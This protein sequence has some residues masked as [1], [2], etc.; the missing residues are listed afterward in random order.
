MLPGLIANPGAMSGTSPPSVDFIASGGSSPS[1]TTWTFSLTLPSYGRT[2]LLLLG[3]SMFT[4]ANGA[5]ITACSWN[6]ISGTALGTSGIGISAN[7]HR[8]SLYS[9]LVPAGSQGTTA[10]ISVTGSGSAARA[11]FGAWVV[12]D[13]TSTTPISAPTDNNSSGIVLSLGYGTLNAGDVVVGAVHDY[14]TSNHGWTWSS[15]TEDYDANVTT[16]TVHYSGSHQVAASGGTLTV[17]ATVD[18]ATNFT[19]AVGVGAAFR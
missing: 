8:M 6:G 15:G 19:Y 12:K 11:M 16:T 13:Y 10:N 1:A 7:Y 3:V 5:T 2:V 14:R 18:D 17:T 4:A 9:V